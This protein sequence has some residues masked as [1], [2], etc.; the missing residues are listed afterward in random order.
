MLV[1]I[2][3]KYSTSYSSVKTDKKSAV[4]CETILEKKAKIKYFGVN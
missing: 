2:G 1:F 4:L 3:R